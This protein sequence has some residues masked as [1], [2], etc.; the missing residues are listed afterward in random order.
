MVDSIKPTYGSLPTKAK[1]QREIEVSSSQ[2]DKEE[3]PPFAVQEKPVE[4]RRRGDRRSKIGSLGIFDMRTSK[5][6]RKTD[7]PQPPIKTKV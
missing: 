1:Q 5:G 2:S 4:R 7:Y 3:K 6:R